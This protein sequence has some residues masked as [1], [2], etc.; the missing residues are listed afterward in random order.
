MMNLYKITFIHTSPR[1]R[2]DGIKGYLLA[3]N[4]EQV[5]NYI[6]ENLNGECWKD[7]DEA[8]DSEPI[9]LY[10]DD[11]KVI[12]TE[13]FK[14]KMLRIKGEQND[15]DY[16]FSDDDYYGITLYGWELVIENTEGDYSE[17]IELGIIS[18]CV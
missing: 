18:N 17:M 4:D 7:A 11:Y 9:E 3:E 8:E 2:E 16:D 1:D 13:T 14:Q 5:Y 10:D 12:G 6:D 15:G